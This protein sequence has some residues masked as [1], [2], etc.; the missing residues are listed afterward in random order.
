MKA[1][2]IIT[3][4]DNLKPNVQ[5]YAQKR[6]WLDKIESDIRK[7][8]ARYSS[9]SGDTSF[10]HCEDPELFLDSNYSDIYVYYL[11]SMIDL[12]NQDVAMY[13]N[14]CAFFNDLFSDW[15][16]KWRREHLPQSVSKE[17]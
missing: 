7:Y 13:N 11:I 8:A 4:C 12:A 15:Q 5:S 6:K 9:H 1:T 16:K 10:A 2:D 14:S 17:G 3:R